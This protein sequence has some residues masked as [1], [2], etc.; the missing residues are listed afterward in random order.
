MEWSRC[1]RTLFTLH[2]TLAMDQRNGPHHCLASQS[3]LRFLRG[4]WLVVYQA[5]GGH[6]TSGHPALVMG[7]L[8]SSFQSHH[9]C[10]TKGFLFLL[11][12]CTACMSLVYGLG[13]LISHICFMSFLV[14]F[15]SSQEEISQ[16]RGS[17]YTMNGVV[18]AF[19]LLVVTQTTLHYAQRVCNYTLPGNY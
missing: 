15:V 10:I 12:S 11:L 17:N 13:W 6:M 14:N 18:I 8:R 16:S 4:V 3:L 5:L 19:E 1:E 2:R 7:G 9:P